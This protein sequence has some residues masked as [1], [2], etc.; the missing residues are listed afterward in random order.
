M[1]VDD[2]ANIL[3]VHAQI[4]PTPTHCNKLRTEVTI[5][6]GECVAEGRQIISTLCTLVFGVTAVVTEFC[7][8]FMNV[9]ASWI[10]KRPVNSLRNFVLC[11]STLAH[12]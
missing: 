8:C 3:G 12:P 2:V 10:C 7:W 5:L 6:C 9:R 4:Q 1:D 11:C